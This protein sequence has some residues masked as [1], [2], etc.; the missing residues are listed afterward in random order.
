VDEWEAPGPLLLFA[1]AQEGGW[2]LRGAG[3]EA[4]ARI[5]AMVWG[6]RR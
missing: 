6:A 5:G 2:I 1:F 3:W 4:A